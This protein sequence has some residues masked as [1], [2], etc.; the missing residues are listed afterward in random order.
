MKKT[1]IIPL[2]KDSKG[3]LGKN[4][5][6]MLGRPLFSWVLTEAVFSHLDEVYVFTDDIEIIDY[7]NKEYHWTTKV[8]ALLRSAENATDTASTES[9][10]VEFAA[11][12]NYDFDVLCLLQATS[13][14]TTASDINAVLAKIENEKYDSALTVVNTHRFSWNADGTPQNYDV[15]N[16]P[17]RQDFEGLLI[18]NGAVYATTKA[19]FVNSKNRV[20]AKIGLVQMP[21]N[22]LVE[23]DSMTDW[24]IAEE[25]LASRLKKSKKHQRIGYLVLDVDGVFTNGQVFF[26][27]EGELAKAFDMRD[28]MGL[29]ILRQHQVEVV[30]ITSE[31]S[32]LVA[33]RM[34]KLQIEH[35]FLGVK[36]K[37]AFLQ[38]FTQTRNISFGA[39]A[40]IGDDVND[41]A[42]ICAVGWSFTPANATEII[43]Q[44]AD[45]VLTKP[46]AE[47]AIREACEWIMKYNE[48]Y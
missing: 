31:N 45:C 39:L 13:P 29:E 42:N 5:K 25:L 47:G 3:I 27:A 37:Y 21:E 16:R 11:Q 19:A 14:L 48:R 38:H 4:K 36:D 26:S 15:F 23:I 43:K 28:G 12:I 9:A 6:K 2:R 18:E 41:W 10:M 40:Y 46:S 22:T 8:K 34:K 30:V 1:A 32:P 24:K 35:T 7:I 44:H 33:Q 17:R 20:S